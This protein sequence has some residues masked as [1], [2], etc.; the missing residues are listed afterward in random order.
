MHQSLPNITAIYFVPCASLIPNITEKH[1]AGLPVAIFPLPYAIEHYGN[2]SCEA[3]QEYVDGGFLVYYEHSSDRII[4]IM[5]PRDSLGVRTNI[6][7]GSLTDPM[8]YR[9][10]PAYWIFVDKTIMQMLQ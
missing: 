4:E 5:S 3:E 9:M 8:K 10:V 2:A 1:R 6:R 7:S